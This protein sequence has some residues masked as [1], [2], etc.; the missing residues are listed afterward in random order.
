[1]IKTAIEQMQLCQIRFYQKIALKKV[2]R[3]NAASGKVDFKA[4]L[5]ALSSIAKYFDTYY[6]KFTDGRSRLPQDNFKR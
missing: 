6:A 2:T 3:V 5:L 4:I 1:M